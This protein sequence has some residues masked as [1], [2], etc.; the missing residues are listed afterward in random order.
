MTARLALP[1]TATAF[2]ACV[3]LA[4]CGNAQAG[5]SSA[6]ATSPTVTA[7][8]T[9]TPPSPEA[10]TSTS[11][12]V[13]TSPD[14][15]RTSEPETTV[16]T[17]SA[18]P[19]ATPTRSASTP[20]KKAGTVKQRSIEDYGDAAIEA[21]AA[22][23]RATLAKYVSPKARAATSSTLATEL[24][25]V[26]CDGDMCSYANEDGKRVTFTFDRATVKAGRTGGIIGIKV[27]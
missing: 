23:D 2:L 11:D 22:G 25:R 8:A 20:A 7:V 6:T 15:S 26:A 18:T 24:L 4:G 27:D 19:T 21:W 12:E 10:T 9:T 16:L 3:A 17:H 1:A 5:T 13:T 14:V